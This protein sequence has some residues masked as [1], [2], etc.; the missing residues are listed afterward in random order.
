M[1]PRRC[2]GTVTV[3]C[4]HLPTRAMTGPKKP[5]PEE[6]DLFR[7]SI[8]P[9]KK[10]RHDKTS[11]VKNRPAPWPRKHQDMMDSVPAD[12][13][14]DA[15]DFGEVS[16]SETL[17]HARPGIQKRV[18]QRLKRGQLATGAELD[19]HGMTAAAA[20]AALL[21]FIDV[22][23]EQQI[24]SVRI[25]HGKGYGSGNAAPVLKNR[26]NSWLRQHHDVLAF[27]SARIEDGGSGA[28]YVLL[29]SRR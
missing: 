20:R 28:L 14:S 9:V 27:N 18:L 10:T 11:P 26:V 21:V 16:G 23:C 17:A 1:Q 25:I 2:A 6:I 24:R 4:T 19:L 15:R 12:R 7:R 22:C 13:F 29:R 5:S 3:L 8:G